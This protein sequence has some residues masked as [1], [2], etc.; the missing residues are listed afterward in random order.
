M[1]LTIMLP[2]NR[3]TK[4]SRMPLK[5]LLEVA[6]NGEYCQKAQNAINQGDVQ[7]D[8]AAGNMRIER[9]QGNGNNSQRIDSHNTIYHG[10]A[11]DQT[12]HAERDA[13]KNQNRSDNEDFF[14]QRSSPNVP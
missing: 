5:T 6:G 12:Q 8:G 14:S 1:P 3:K 13:K 7:I 11:E 9:N 10:A 4:S 2:H